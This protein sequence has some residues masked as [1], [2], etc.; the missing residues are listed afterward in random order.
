MVEQSSPTILQRSASPIDDVERPGLTLS[1][2]RRLGLGKLLIFG[3]GGDATFARL[4]GSPSPEAGRQID[5][6]GLTFSWMGPGEW[7]ISGSEQDVVERLTQ[8]DQTGGD[9][10]LTVNLT[11]ARTSFLLGGPDARIALA[12]HCPLDLCS[13]AFPV[14]AVARSLLGQTSIFIARLSDPPDGA[15]F[16]IVVDQTMGPYAARLLAKP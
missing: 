5:T 12:A 6:Q 16:R 13:N 1:M 4:V 7:L 2:E 15:R 9:D 8:L 3:N 14:G 11:D 10:T